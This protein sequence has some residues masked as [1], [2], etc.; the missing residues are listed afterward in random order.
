MLVLAMVG[1]QAAQAQ[2]VP[3]AGVGPN[4]SRVKPW[5]QNALSEL[6]NLPG[7]NAV[8]VVS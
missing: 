8:K 2:L 5:L 3:G 1:I 4:R 6:A 7:T